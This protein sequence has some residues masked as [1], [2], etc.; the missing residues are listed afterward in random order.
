M[1]LL[2]RKC[3]LPAFNEL[4]VQGGNLGLLQSMPWMVAMGLPT[5][6][7][8][9]GKLTPLC[10]FNARNTCTV[11][12]DKTNL[13]QLSINAEKIL[14][15]DFNSIYAPWEKICVE[16]LE[17][18]KQAHRAPLQPNKG[19]KLAWEQMIDFWKWSVFIDSF[20]VG[21][22]FQEINRI[23]KLHEISKQDVQILTTP[24]ELSYLQAY[25]LA[26]LRA[27]K[28]GKAM[29]QVSSLAE[30][31]HWIKTDYTNLNEFTVTEALKEVENRKEN[32]K[33][34]NL[35]RNLTS[36]ENYSAELEQKQKK[37]LANYGLK[38]NPMWLYNKLVAWRDE[39]KKFN[40]VG[41][42]A[43]CKYSCEIMKENKLPQE[44]F[45]LVLATEY[46]SGKLPSLKELKQRFDLGT[47][48]V[49]FDD[50]IELA[51]GKAAQKLHKQIEQLR[52]NENFDLRGQ[53]ACLGRIT[54]KVRIVRGPE[55]FEKF[56]QGE[57]LV[58][59]MTRPE[60][61]FLMK[62]AA[63]IITDEGGVTCHAA[64]VSR[65]LNVPCIVGTQRATKLLKTGQ[66]VELDAFHG[67]VKLSR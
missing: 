58:A 44:M 50:H 11:Y 1:Q 26:I 32:N 9:K 28:S 33:N 55:D 51:S 15:K 35:Q 14:S 45:Q 29:L 24:A 60:H 6:S 63:G 25:E 43:L 37:V 42:Y 8:F 22:D 39:R 27:A 16:L 49:A 10:Y 46:L 67:L 38:E 61:V 57:I 4:Y 21:L 30:D 20:D 54:G 34:E 56:K 2:K 3:K 65:E 40:Y 47:F 19:F 66:E 23:S 59:V 64:I 62:K 48:I 13:Q 7:I 5:Y 41:L 17:I 52:G 31:F 12:Y 18:S 53:P 36:L